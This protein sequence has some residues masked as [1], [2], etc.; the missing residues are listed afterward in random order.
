MAQLAQSI[1]GIGEANKIY[2]TNRTKDKA[3]EL[4]KNFPKLK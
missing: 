1:V 3:E 2:V 4:K